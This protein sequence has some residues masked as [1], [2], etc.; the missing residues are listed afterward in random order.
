MNRPADGVGFADTVDPKSRRMHNC[1]AG[2]R[3]YFA[4]VHDCFAGA[5][6]SHGA[7]KI[8]KIANLDAVNIYVVLAG[9][10][11]SPECGILCDILWK[12]INCLPSSTIREIRATIS[13]GPV[14]Y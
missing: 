4:G 5:A 2:V 1:F 9:A 14:L 13:G 8:V 7:P 6:S 10:A 11:S 3:N 12:V